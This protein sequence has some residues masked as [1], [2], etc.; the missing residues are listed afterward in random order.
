[1]S[2][3]IHPSHE[4]IALMTNPGLPANTDEPISA[5]TQ[6]LEETE[7]ETKTT[8]TSQRNQSIQSNSISMRI[9]DSGEIS[10]IH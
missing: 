4:T 2:F 9:H 5:E 7:I 3:A 6:T 10:D 1:M 8:T